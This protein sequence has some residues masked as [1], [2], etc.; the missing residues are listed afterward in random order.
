MAGTGK[1][2]EVKIRLGGD[3]DASLRRAFSKAESEM[4]AL[5]RISNRRNQSF[6]NGVNQLDSMSNRAFSAMANGAAAAS[7]GLAAGFTAATAAGLS[8]EEQ[9]SAVQAI[10]QASDEHMAQLSELAKKMGRETKFSA[11][12]AGQGLE[13]MAAAGW[14]VKDMLRGLPGI[15]NLAAASGE[16]L[17]LVSNIVTDSMT[18]FGLE[19]SQASMFA[20]VLAQ[21]AASSNTDVAKLGNTFQYV[22]PV[23]GALGFSIQDVA[24]AA[25]LMANAGIKGDQAGTTM[26]AMFSRLVKPTAEV[27]G[28]MDRL[29]LSVTNVDGSMRPLRDIL[30]DMRREFSGLS[31]S[32]RA[33]SAAALAGQEAMSGLL[34]LIN[35]SDED[36]NSLAD[37]IEHSAGAAQEMANVRLD[38]LAGD[39]TIL[40]SGLEGLG[41]EAYEGY[42]DFLRGGVQELTGWVGTLTETLEEELPNL[43]RSARNWA[44]AAE[45]IFGPVQEMGGWFL[46]HPDTVASGIK[47]IGAA[48]LTFKA[49]K[50]AT[51][52]VKVLGSL[53]G[54]VSAWPVAA[55][56]L[57]I[58][59]LVGIHSAMK[60]ASDS[61]AAENLAEHF[62]DVALSIEDIDEAARHIVGDDLFNGIEAMGS[63]AERAD[64]FY[65]SMKDSLED[66]RRTNWKL[67]MGIELNAD[68]A[69]SYVD[70]VDS[71][72]E[73][74]QNYISERGYE[75]DLAVKVVFGEDG[76]AFAEDSSAFYQSLLAQLDPLRQ[77]ISEVL[78]DI[79]ENGLT[80]DKEKIVSEYL[81]QMGEIT[82]MI[83]D[84]ENAAKMQMIETQFAGAALTPDSFQNLQQAISEY[85]KEAQAGANEAYQTILTSLNAQKIAGDEG[86]EGGIS[87]EEFASRSAEATRQYYERQAEAI[88]NGYQIMENTIMAT[89]GDEIRP[90]MEQI[91]TQLTESLNEIFEN[92]N[93][94][95]AQDYAW[96]IENAMYEALQSVDISEDAKN[97]IGML[98]EGMAPTTEQIDSLTEQIRKAGG[99][100][101]QAIQ[102]AMTNFDTI[103]AAS[104]DAQGMWGLIA[105]QITE[106]PQR[107]T[108]IELAYQQG[109]EI[110]A[111]VVDG[112]EDAYPEI[113]T[114]TQEALKQAQRG[115]EQGFSAN[116]PINLHAYV[117]SAEGQA[118]TSRATKEKGHAEGGIFDTPHVA[119]FAEDGPEAVVPLDGSQNAI[120]IWQEAGRLLGVMQPSESFSQIGE[121]IAALATSQPAGG[122]GGGGIPAFSPIVN[123]Y[124]NASR[125]DVDGG[126][127][128][129]FEQFVEYAERYEEKRRRTRF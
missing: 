32:E 88:L 120:S 38:N 74:A 93:I 104:G 13:Y 55:A 75:L 85:T 24:T 42:S 26:R 17:A 19:A 115:L 47:G 105:R 122:S 56:G 50:V 87:A 106:S 117:R 49:A 53:S 128:M 126:L 43:R 83:T 60:A 79:T 7:A 66:I 54:L 111:E 41:I 119:W 23:A 70:A 64:S 1:D 67:S 27:Q 82:A 107:A 94:M 80:L 61:R 77:D 116:I 108:T 37:A 25:G 69:D 114:A 14:P 59:G 30:S 110:P 71:Y 21:A 91:N 97:A 63:S 18:A 112:I 100:I 129:T 86:M 109:G 58:G 5:Y 81:S 99:E 78:Q 22:A 16:D 124:G 73:N 101:P 103:S 52:G 28:V 34:A 72:V 84:A 15:M 92:P 102:E 62:G 35:A 121:R 39:I 40:K 113:M 12:E 127:Q 3:V 2:Y 11:T 10:A 118:F 125:E 96:T 6:L 95:D 123:I 89:Y 8:F 33:S 31:E 90:A 9:M 36:F 51:T 44:D 65:Q 57:A 45:N 68:D 76:G 48:L 46:E 29:G 98:V 20:D 4:A